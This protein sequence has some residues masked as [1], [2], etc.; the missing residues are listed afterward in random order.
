[1]KKIYFILIG[2]FFLASTLQAQNLELKGTVLDSLDKSPLI[3]ANVILTGIRDTTKKFF[4]TTDLEG[5]FSLKPTQRQAYRLKITFIGYKDMDTTI[6]FRQPVLDLG[7]IYLAPKVSMLKQVEVVGQAA[8]AQQKGDTV[9]L[10]TKAYKMNKDASAEDLIKKMPGLTVEGGVVQ[11]QGENVGRVLVDG[12]EFFGDDAVIALRNLPSEVI[13]KIQVFDRLSEQSQFSGFDDGNTI[14]TI[15]IVTKADSRNGQFGRIYGGYGTD[16]RYQAGA[17]LNYFKE[18]RRISLVALSNNINQQNFSSQDLAGVSGNQGGGNRGQGGRGQGGAG[19]GGQGG[20]NWQG[21]NNNANNFLIGQQSGI[22]NTHSI[23]LNYSDNWGKKV[24]IT[25]SYFFNRSTNVNAQDLA[26]TL[27]L[28]NNTNQLY[29]QNSLSESA[30]QNH[31]LNARL[32]YKIDSANSL[33]ITPRLSFQFNEASTNLT[34]AN[35]LANGTL[36]NR[37][38][39]LNRNNVFAYNFGNEMLFRHAFKKRGRTYSVSLNTNFNNRDNESFLFAQNEFFQGNII[40]TTNQNQRNDQITNAY[41]IEGNLSYTEPINRQ[42]ILQLDYNISYNNNYSDRRTNAFN[43]VSQTFNIL[44]TLLSNTF[45]NDY[46][47]HRGGVSYRYNNRKTQ[48]TAGMSYQNAQLIGEQLFPINNTVQ[49]NFNNLLPNFNLRYNFSNTKNIRLFYRTSVNAPS[50]NQLQNVVNNTNPLFLTSGNPDLVQ[51]YNH[52]LV[53]RYSANNTERA[54]TFFTFFNVNYTQ[55]PISNAV[56]IAQRDTILANEIVLKRGSQ[57]SQPVNLDNQLN[58]NYFSVY[59]LPIKKLKITVNFN[60][61]VGYT[62]T[63]SLI[64]NTTNISDSYVISQGLT[65]ASNISENID[66]NLSYSGN[67]GIVKNS[68]QAQLDNTYYS[69]TT[70]LRTN[71]LFRNFLLQSDIGHTWFTGL[72]GGFNQNFLLWNMSIGRKLW[73]QKGEI[74]LSVFDLLNQNNSI[75]RNVSESYIE[76]VRTQVLRQYY[77]L[78]FTYNIRNFGGKK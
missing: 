73:N 13:E 47:S 21:G 30:N 33:L 9:E 55:N 34:G 54:T 45:D 4:I 37:T 46:I 64:N 70:N 38:Q 68:I 59:G 5:N 15:N 78:I 3:S 53:L 40:N 62:R 12:R 77:M 41:T 69:Q 7:N 63:P 51:S 43:E 11:A 23:G 27:F 52:R 17:T 56:T 18:A 31:R 72:A 58:L 2:L 76:D 35:A 8:L 67:Y 29:D 61:R 6:F 74:K 16:D 22:T 57:F 50:V 24:T 20:G 36:L 71:F 60:T 66:F 10:S 14:K 19:R 65:I 49:R 42:S 48:F 1:M 28:S 32:E 25:G 44:D 75:V 26:R 39:N